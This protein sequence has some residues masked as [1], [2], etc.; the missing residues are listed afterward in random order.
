MRSSRRATRSA[1][2]TFLAATLTGTTLLTLGS[3]SAVLAKTEIEVTTAAGGRYQVGT[4][5]PFIVSLSADRAV[6]GTVIIRQDGS[7]VATQPVEVSG[8]STDDIVIVVPTVPWQASYTAEFEA[9]DDEDDSS[10]RITTTA[11]GGDELVGVL[12]NLAQRNLPEQGSLIVDLGVARFY[13]LHPSLLDL[14][15][16]GLGTFSQVLATTEDLDALTDQQRAALSS[17]VADDGGTLILDEASDGAG[18]F[19]PTTP[20]S[21]DQVSFGLGRIQFTSG[22]ASGGAFDD[23]VRPTPA[24]S[25]EDFPWASQMSGLPTTIQLARDAGVRVPAISSLILALLAYAVLVGPV[26]WIFLKRRRREP[27][28][29]AAIPLTALLVSLGVYVVGRQLRSSTTASHAT[30]VADLP[31]GRE[32]AS[33]VL[34]TS[35]NGGQAGIRLPDGW[36]IAPSSQ[37]MMFEGPFGQAPGLAG[38]PIERNGRLT[39]ELDPG[40]I[41]V[42]S[43]EGADPGTGEPSFAI[44]LVPDGPDLIGSVTNTT[45]QTLTNV[46]ISSGQAVSRIPT[47]A[48]GEVKAVTLRN[49]NTVRIQGDVVT[50]QLNGGDPWTPNDGDTNPGVLLDYLAR[51]PRLRGAGIVM[52]IGWTRAAEPT[53]ETLSGVPIA[54]GRTAFLTA[55]RLDQGKGDTSFLITS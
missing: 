32:I 6:R 29:W 46:L 38:A 3:S 43:V 28:L 51:S 8:G 42:L 34:V 24:R 17:W 45:S 1:L 23:L 7:P 36:R 25:G 20:L 35:P 37:Q 10:T 31:N 52:A 30:V 26:L 2:P 41:S 5:T 16:E 18:P 14:G 49:P 11:A 39:V 27:L 44:D 15:P 55:V 33:H 48:P 54:N 40:G 53:I 50:E 9:E 4:A 22:A 21:D 47:L 19:T 13:P 12:P